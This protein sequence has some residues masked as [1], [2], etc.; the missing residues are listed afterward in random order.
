[1]SGGNAIILHTKDG[2]KKM[3]PVGE[4]DKFKA[5]GWFLKD[6]A[7]YTEQKLMQDKN[8]IIDLNARKFDEE[9]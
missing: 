6:A 9:D 4:V 2:G 3:V 7:W 5:Q 8:K 1:M